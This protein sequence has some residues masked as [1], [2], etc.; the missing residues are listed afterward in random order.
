MNGHQNT[1]HQSSQTV[2]RTKPLDCEPKG[3]ESLP[4]AHVWL[5]LQPRSEAYLRRLMANRF[6]VR[7]AL[8]AAGGRRSSNVAPFR[9]RS[10]FAGQW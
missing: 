10:C 2:W 9:E 5:F 8:L 3:D 1:S 7:T 6:G 4:S